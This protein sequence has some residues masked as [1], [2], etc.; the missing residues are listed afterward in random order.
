MRD[1]RPLLNQSIQFPQIRSRGVSTL[2]INLGYT[3]TNMPIQ[4]F[5]STLVSK[6]LFD[7]YMNT[8]KAA[9]RPEN[10]ESVMCKDLV[11][12]D[13]QRFVLRDH[14]YGCTAG[15]GSSCGGALEPVAGLNAA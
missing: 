4:R 5:G 10:L 11:S 12:I 8:L 3:I 15:Q 6:G 1:V 2:Q 13:W 9:H 14:C 7:Q